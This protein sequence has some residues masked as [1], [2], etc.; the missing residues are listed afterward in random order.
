M[1]KQ[2][3][4]IIAHSEFS[5]LEKLLLLLD[6]YRFDIYLHIDSKVKNFDFNYYKNLIKKSNLYFTKRINVKWGTFTQIE[7]ELLLLEAAIKNNYKYYHLISGVDLPIKSNDYIYNFFNENNYE[8]IGFSDNNCI[9]RVKYYHLFLNNIKTSKLMNKLEFHLVKLQ[10]NIGID[11]TKN[12]NIVFK[13]GCNWFSI[14]NDLARYV[15]ENKKFIKDN[16]KYSKCADEMFLQ[17]IV[18]NSSF[19]DKVYNNFPSEHENTK[20]LID[21]ERGEPYTYNKSDYDEIVNSNC[22]FARKFSTTN[23]DNYDLVLKIYKYVRDLNEN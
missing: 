10:S 11:R 7:C 4:L 14:T 21:W 17:T 18:F 15:L 20:R 1:N 19:K 2:V 23:K 16:F 22:L 13:K 9:D 6:D 3:F 12:K 8:F 5:I